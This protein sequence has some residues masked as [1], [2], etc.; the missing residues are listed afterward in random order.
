MSRSRK[1]SPFVGHTTAPS[2]KPWKQQH[3]RRVRR[4]AHQTLGQTTD[5]DSVPSNRYA[6]GSADRDGIKD[7]KQRVAEPTSKWMRK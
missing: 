1:T 3:A 5:G 4:A 7:G 6:F 2:D